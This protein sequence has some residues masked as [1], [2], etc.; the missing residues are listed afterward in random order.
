MTATSQEFSRDFFR[1]LPKIELHRHLEG[2]L[3]LSTMLDIAQLHDLDL[4]Y[5]DVDQFRSL[6]QVVSGEPYNFQNFLGK[7]TSL[8]Y[9]YQ[10][11]EAIKRI[12]HEAI[13][14]AA[15]DHIRYMELR[16]TPVA[17]SRI[18]SFPLG[19]AMDWVIET[20]DQTSAQYGI[21]V[22][23]IANVNRHEPL[24]LAEEVIHLA[25]ERKDRGIL[26][27]D[28]GGNEADFP[29]EDFAPLFQQA[30][31]EG[32]RISIHAGEWGGP[33]RISLAIESLGAE[34]IGHGVR[35]LED[36]SVTATA[37]D[38][39]IAFEVCPTSNHQSGVITEINEHPLLKMIEAGLMVTVNTDDPGISQI[40]LS[41]EYQV[42]TNQLGISLPRLKFLILDAAKASFLPENDKQALIA[43][44]TDELETQLPT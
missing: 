13:E 15:S 24:D 33:E 35:V 14:D 41:N 43:K 29:G 20:V 21:Q 19:E 37:R 25:I 39:Q 27:V 9:F 2:S 5:R 30:K 17:L 7:F 4:P 26:A 6:V 31:Q 23:L 3:R 16:F 1:T 40:D 11:P 36:A 22:R 42:C 18:K 8:R 44:M 34:R 10:S 38:R 28:M 32:L 12:T